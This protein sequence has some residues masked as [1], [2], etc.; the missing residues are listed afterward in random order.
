MA[1]DT[2]LEYVVVHELCHFYHM[3]HSSDFWN[4]VEKMIPDYKV[5]RNWLKEHGDQMFWLG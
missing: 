4:L 5:K 2:V 1:P 3:D